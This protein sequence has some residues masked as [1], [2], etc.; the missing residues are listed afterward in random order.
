MSDTKVYLLDF[1]T[2][3]LDSRQVFWPMAPKGPYQIRIYGALIEH[4]EGRFL[5]DTG[6][7]RQLVGSHL[8]SM[9]VDGPGGDE[10]K[11]Q[12]V[13]GQLALLG[14]SPTDITHVVNSHLHVDH[15]GGNKYCTKATTICH[16]LELE[17][18]A[19]P[20]PFEEWVY[21][22][23]S[24]AP[25]LRKNSN[26]PEPT[27][28]YTPRLETLA[29]DQEIAKG[30]TLFET[31][32][33]SPGH[34]SLLVELAN[35]RPILFTADASYTEKHLNDN[36]IAGFHSDVKQSFE[37]LQRLR[38]LAKK[39]DAELFYAHDSALWKTW[40]HGPDYYS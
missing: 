15:V 25:G 24:F 32:G 9:L 18:A 16:R 28:N 4:K 23:M 20:Q 19:N 1:G 10:E 36:L 35:R 8:D 34:Y 3:D 30:V 12:N 2:M 40:K 39:Y 22:D 27:P 26:A 31:P 17:T 7:D 38:D 21:I 6:V 29:G 11:M 33:H 14:F 13:P 5:F 37:S